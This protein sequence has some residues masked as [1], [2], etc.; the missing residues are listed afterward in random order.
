MILLLAGFIGFTQNAHADLSDG[1][2]SYYPF[3]GNSNDNGSF[4]NHGAEYGGIT[5]ANGKYGQALL[6]DGVNDYIKIPNENQY[7]F[8]N[9]TFSLSG[10]FKT[11]STEGAY[12]LAKDLYPYCCSSGGW[13]VSIS[14]KVGV[15]S[16]SAASY[17]PFGRSTNNTYNDNKW[18]HF[19]IV[20]KTSTTVRTDN[21]VNIYIDGTLEQTDMSYDRDNYI[22]GSNPLYIGRRDDPRSSANHYNGMIDEIRIYNRALTTSE[23]QQLAAGGT[24]PQPPPTPTSGK[25]SLMPVF[26]VLLGAPNLILDDYVNS[27]V[28]TVPK[29]KT[30][31]VASSNWY[32]DFLEDLVHEG[33]FNLIT[34]GNFWGG[35]LLSIIDGVHTIGTTHSYETWVDLLDENGVVPTNSKI[36][37]W[38]D[39]VK[40]WKVYDGKIKAGKEYNFACTVN[41]G[42]G[43]LEVTQASF[44]TEFT[45]TY[46]WH[47]TFFSSSQHRLVTNSPVNFFNYDIYVGTQV[48]FYKD[49]ITIPS[50]ADV[51]ELYLSCGHDIANPKRY[52]IEI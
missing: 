48:F 6:L 19:A 24:T 9:K 18:H 2:V 40:S 3:N 32:E 49:K 35:A 7:D 33:V 26:K 38:D 43:Q 50:N 47:D 34:K 22:G 36:T 44:P 51:T 4:S 42:A 27:V 23:I 39:A 28:W 29:S 25:V 41:R 20:I 10:W 5:Y 16:K 13:G 46:N 12:I 30:L 8:E 37:V 11:D 45:T 31:P 1:L 52:L 14:G 21:L 15:A 17:S